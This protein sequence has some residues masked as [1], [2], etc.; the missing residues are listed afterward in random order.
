[1]LLTELPT[2]FCIP[3]LAFVYFPLL[4][5]GPGLSSWGHLMVL[6]LERQFKTTTDLIYLVLLG[7]FSSLILFL[8]WLYNLPHN[9]PIIL[10]I[11]PISSV[12]NSRDPPYYWSLWIFTFGC[13]SREGS[14][15][16]FHK[17]C[18]LAGVSGNLKK[19]SQLSRYKIRLQI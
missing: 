3:L 19:P 18:G 9:L 2:L 15:C 8:K 12:M 6:F 5:L 4:G 14:V 1:M 16:L 13:L 10:V 17:M 7:C 11:A